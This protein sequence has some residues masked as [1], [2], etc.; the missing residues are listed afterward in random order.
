[1]EAGSRVRVSIPGEGSRQGTV[2]GEY[3]IPDRMGRMIR[4]NAGTVM[5]DD[6]SSRQSEYIQVGPDI[7]KLDCEGNQP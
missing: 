5:R 3:N 1:M 4:G 7:I 6:L 2:V